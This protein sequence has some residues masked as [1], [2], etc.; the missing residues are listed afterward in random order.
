MQQQGVLLMNLGTPDNHTPKAVKRY[1]REFLNDPRVVDI[2]MPWRSILVNGII[3][4]FRYKKSA[5]AYQQIWSEKGSPLLYFTQAMQEALA[6][7]LGPDYLVALGMRYG[8]PSI[9]SALRALEGCEKIHIIPLFPQYSSAATGSAI[10]KALK[11]ISDA[12]NAPALHIVNE[13]YEHPGFIAA[14]AEE[15]KQAIAKDPVDKLVFSYHG[16]PERH[17]DKSECRAA[18]NHQ[19]A[20]PA[21]TS[22]IVTARSVMRQRV[23]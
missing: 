18:C 4:P 16:L 6:M 21:V 14:C 15:I 20:C 8:N 1:L 17:I 13:F 10:E 23:R 5:A 3:V 22:A 7:R 19:E 2:P 9:A 12:W 11:C